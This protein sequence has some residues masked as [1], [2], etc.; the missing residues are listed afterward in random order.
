MVQ[1]LRK[2]QKIAQRC[3][4]FKE[5]YLKFRKKNAFKTKNR[6]PTPGSIEASKDRSRWQRL[7]KAY[8]EVQKPKPS[9]AEDAHQHVDLII[10]KKKLYNNTESIYFIK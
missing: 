6:P 10:F 3:Q 9:E 8:V 7:G 2:L 5:T 1:N 4:K